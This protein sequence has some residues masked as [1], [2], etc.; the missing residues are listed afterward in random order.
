[1]VDV[2]STS[3]QRLQVVWFKRDLR[4]FDHEPLAAASAQGPV[5]PL[6]VVEPELWQLPDMSGR[7]YAFVRE[8]LLELRTEL[9]RL[10][11]PLVIRTGQVTDV[12]ADFNRTCGIGKLWAHEETGNDWTYRR[13]L[14]VAAWCREHG[15]AFQELP[16]NGVI[17][18]IRDR[19]GWARHWDQTMG[20]PLRPAPSLTPLGGI[21]PGALPDHRDLGLPHDPC[22]GRQ[23][24]GRSS[25][26]ECLESFLLRR[27]RTYRS[28]MSSPLQGFDACSRISPHLAWGT[29]SLREVAQRTRQAQRDLKAGAGPRGQGWSGALS[30]FSGRLHWHCHFMQKLEDQPDLEFRALHPETEN[31]RPSLPDPVRLEA[32]SRGETGLPFVDACMRALQQTGWMN[33]RM[34]AMLMAVSSYHLWLDWRKPGQHLARLFT[35]YEPG[36]HW[37]QVQMQSGT[38]GINTIRIYNPVK[39]GKDQDPLGTFIRRWVPELSDIPDAT[40]HEPWRAE[41]AGTVLGSAYPFPIVD[42]LEAAKEARAKVWALRTGDDFRRTAQAIQHK[43]GSRKSGIPMRGRK[44]SAKKK[45]TSQLDLFTGPE[46]ASP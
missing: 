22:P 45:P 13:D 20:F 18:R 37:P 7:H 26:L 4:S 32:W 21:D 41:N 19:N 12:L 42:H 43:H 27:G 39:Q 40:L 5:L 31:L 8:S 1:M 11:Q 6:F 29:L 46:D 23:P 24:G 17:R 15:I 25:G 30:S 36:I 38:T 34:R 9:A 2:I 35:D 14:H 33:F 44:A 16:Q 28:A 10:G 3:R